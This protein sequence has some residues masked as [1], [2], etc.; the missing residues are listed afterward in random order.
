MKQKIVRVGFPDFWQTAYETKPEAFYATSGMTD[1]ENRVFAKPLEEPLH[2][3]IRHLAK[4]S[5]N[6]LSALTTL[7]LNGYS[8]DAM[9]IARGI[10]ESSVTVAYLIQHPDE[11]DDFFD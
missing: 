11:L 7:L 9:K 8:H 3:V 10:F 6:C 4:M 5:G 1:L 2:K